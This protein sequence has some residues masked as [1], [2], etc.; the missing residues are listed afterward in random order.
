MTK[1]LV[2]LWLLWLI[3]LLALTFIWVRQSKA[4]LRKIEEADTNFEFPGWLKF[5][6]QS[7]ALNFPYSR[8]SE[9]YQA[10]QEYHKL[11]KLWAVVAGLVVVTRV[12]IIVGS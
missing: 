11:L 1:V 2:P 6:K 3:L 5:L 4:L 12:L 10:V 8:D 9:L 7:W